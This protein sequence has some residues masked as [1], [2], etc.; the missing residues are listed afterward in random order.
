[1]F[2]REV[3]NFSIPKFKDLLIFL[4]DIAKPKDIVSSSQSVRIDHFTYWLA[5]SLICFI[6][7]IMEPKAFWI[8]TQCVRQCYGL[9]PKCTPKTHLSKASSQLMVLCRSGLQSFM[10]QDHLWR[11]VPGGKL[12]WRCCLPPQPLSSFILQPHELS[13]FWIILSQCLTLNYT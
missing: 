2:C 11:H 10:S 7:P 8:K 9:E 6:C 4:L 3:Y 13:E 1:M 12:T 5:N